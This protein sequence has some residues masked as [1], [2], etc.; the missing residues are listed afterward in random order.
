MPY[1]PVNIPAKTTQANIKRYREQLDRIG[2]SFDWDREVRTSDPN[3]YK[4]TQWIFIQLFESYYDYDADKAKPI[5]DL[6]NILKKRVI[7][8][9]MPHVMKIHQNFQQ[10]IGKFF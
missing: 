5:S 10:K 9:S 7:V 3:Y 6:I 1:K 8:K 4:W 2:F